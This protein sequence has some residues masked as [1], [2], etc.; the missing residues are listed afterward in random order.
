MTKSFTI[1][2]NTS[3]TAVLGSSAPFVFDP[4]TDYMGQERQ[5]S[6]LPKRRCPVRI[7]SRT[8]AHR[9][10]PMKKLIL[11]FLAVSVFVLGGMA[12]VANAAPTSTI[13]Q[14]LQNHGF[15]WKRNVMPSCLK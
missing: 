4:T 7:G 6:L 14:N 15:I 2:A 12:I 1:P 8:N 5:P 11:S 10:I 3:I 13:V 9:A